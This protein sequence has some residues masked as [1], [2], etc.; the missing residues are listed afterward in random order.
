MGGGFRLDNRQRSLD[1]LRALF[2]IF[3]G[4]EM[5]KFPLTKNG[6]EEKMQVYR[7]LE[8]RF[9]LDSKS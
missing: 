6:A 8:E 4:Y 9:C 7:R 3:S 2:S 1:N 5:A